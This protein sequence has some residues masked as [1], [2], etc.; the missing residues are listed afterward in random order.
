MTG[1]DFRD[2]AVAANDDTLARAREAATADY[3]IDELLGVIDGGRED[4][5]H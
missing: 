4:E 1:E 3:T 5:G 2:R